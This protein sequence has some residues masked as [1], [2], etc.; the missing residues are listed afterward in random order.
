MNFVTSFLQTQDYFGI[1]PSMTIKNHQKY[2]N[3]IGTLLSLII[4]ICC[5]VL[6]IAFLVKLFTH[7]NPSVNTVTISQSISPNITMS[8]DDLIISFGLM[9]RNFRVIDYSSI[10]S[11][12]LKTSFISSSALIILSIN[13]PYE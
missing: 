11:I 8:T 6:T 9:D 12:D 10:F 7:N 1:I 13:T 4:N 5:I 3:I 2:Q